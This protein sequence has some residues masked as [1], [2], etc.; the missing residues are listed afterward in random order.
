MPEK[1]E[2]GRTEKLNDA[3][4]KRRNAKKVNRTR[5][6][7]NAQDRNLKSDFSTVGGEH[8]VYLNH[9]R[10]NREL[11]KRV[12]RGWLRGRLHEWRSHMRIE[13]A[14]VGIHGIY[15]PKPLLGRRGQ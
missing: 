2:Q 12:V 15:N 1:I 9:P 3:A 4:T 8:A 14:A 10:V 6:S 5:S 11:V 13:R 7:D